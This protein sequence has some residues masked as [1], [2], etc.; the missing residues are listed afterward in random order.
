MPKLPV[1]ILA[2]I[3]ASATLCPLSLPH[4]SPRRAEGRRRVLSNRSI[5]RDC[6]ESTGLPPEDVYRKVRVRTFELGGQHDVRSRGVPPRSKRRDHRT[7]R[8]ATA[9]D[10]PLQSQRDPAT[11]P[12]LWALG[13]SG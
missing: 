12:A 3:M 9:R 7:R 5:Y 8:P 13:L 4:G 2:L 1:L 10:R 11:V 6:S